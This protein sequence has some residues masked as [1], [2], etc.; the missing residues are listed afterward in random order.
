M[1][2]FMKPLNGSLFWVMLLWIAWIGYEVGKEAKTNWFSHSSQQESKLIGNEV[3]DSS[4]KQVDLKIE[5]K[6]STKDDS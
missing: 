4:N 5:G 6:K 3:T 2:D 1:S